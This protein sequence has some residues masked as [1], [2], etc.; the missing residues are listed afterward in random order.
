VVEKWSE[1]RYPTHRVPV[2]CNE[3]AWELLEDACYG[4]VLNKHQEG[5]SD[6][7]LYGKL[8]HINPVR[9]YFSCL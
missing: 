6:T 1:H 8:P 5:D 2:R 3:L 7:P 4:A 9:K